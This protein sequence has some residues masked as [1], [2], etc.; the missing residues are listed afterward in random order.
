MDTGGSFNKLR[1]Y[2]R[3]EAQIGFFLLFSDWTYTQK[4]TERDWEREEW[5]IPC[6]TKQAGR[7]RVRTQSTEKLP[8]CLPFDL[9]LDS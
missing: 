7:V 1:L 4:E 5:R 3:E 9:N 2:S 8:L 6:P